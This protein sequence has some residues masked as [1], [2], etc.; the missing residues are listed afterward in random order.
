MNTRTQSSKCLQCNLE[1]LVDVVPDPLPYMAGY[2]VNAGVPGTND[3][4]FDVRTRRPLRGRYSPA[5]MSLPLFRV[6]G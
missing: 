4:D 2:A 3:S 5:A 1:N 6:H